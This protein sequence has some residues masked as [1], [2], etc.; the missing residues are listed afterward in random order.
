[1]GRR[2]RTVGGNRALRE[3]AAASIGAGG[4]KTEHARNFVFSL[5]R[6]FGPGTPVSEINEAEAHYKAALVTRFGLNRN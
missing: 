3:L 2:D 4:A 5:L 6:V 1:M